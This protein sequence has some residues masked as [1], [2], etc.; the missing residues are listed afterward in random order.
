MLASS[1]EQLYPLLA[2]AFGSGDIE[3]VMELYEPDA[4]IV[5]QPSVVMVGADQVRRALQ[6]FLVVNIRFHPGNVE[7]VQ[8][9]DIALTFARWSAVIDG[10]DGQPANLAG[11]SADVLRRGADGGW[12]YVIDQPWADQVTTSV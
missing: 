1:P 12:R 2:D 5:P 6:G 3:R 4:A 7:V 9:G 11:V 10:P 8:T